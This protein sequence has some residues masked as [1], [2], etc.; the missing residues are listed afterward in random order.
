MDPSWVVEWASEL[1]GYAKTIL[2]FIRTVVQ[3]RLFVIWFDDWKH[4]SQNY[5]R[6]WIIQ[7]QSTGINKRE[8]GWKLDLETD[9]AQHCALG[10]LC[11]AIFDISLENNTFFEETGEDFITNRRDNGQIPLQTASLLFG[12]IWLWIIRS[13]LLRLT[14]VCRICHGLDYH[15]HSL[16]AQLQQPEKN[17]QQLIVIIILFNEL[18]LF[19]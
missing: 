18:T 11:N 12:H 14:Q 10:A 6:S 8:F 15:Q 7:W 1:H 17:A 2:S 5:R 13:Y 9:F 16:G 19:L 4:T 3:L